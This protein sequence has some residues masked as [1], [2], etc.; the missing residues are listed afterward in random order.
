MSFKS[1]VEKYKLNKTLIKNVDLTK[2]PWN[3]GIY[4]IELVENK[5]IEIL[6]TTTAVTERFH[7]GKL[8]NQL[9]QKSDLEY[10]L[11]L[12]DDRILY[13]GKAESRNG[14]LRKR[15]CQLKNYAYGICDCHSGGR[16]LWQI[17]DWENS[18]NLYWYEVENA[19][20]LEKYL[21]NLHSS[22]RPNIATKLSYPF[23]NW[24]G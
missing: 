18:L 3:S 12:C 6:D 23:A 15:I 11:S 1:E 16:A 7:K 14:G 17:K 4:I 20:E 21:L 22:E 8:T 5:K 9:F 24:R 2:I 13:I 10:K 19:E